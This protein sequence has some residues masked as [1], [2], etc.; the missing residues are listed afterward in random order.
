LGKVGHAW[1]SFGIPMG[2]VV[3]YDHTDPKQ[4]SGSGDI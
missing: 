3:L 2:K 4:S 1:A